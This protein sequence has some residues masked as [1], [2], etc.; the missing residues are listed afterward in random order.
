MI[1]KILCGVIVKILCGVIVKILCGVIVKILCV[2]DSE[3]IVWCDSENNA[4]R[5]LKSVSFV[6]GLSHFENTEIY[7]RF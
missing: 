2:C 3:N 6:K 5:H 4:P 7:L 1:V